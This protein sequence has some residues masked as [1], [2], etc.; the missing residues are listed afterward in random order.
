MGVNYN[1]NA[2]HHNHPHTPTAYTH[3]LT[4]TH[5]HAHTY[6]QWHSAV[7]SEPFLLSVFRA[8]SQHYLLVWGLE[9]MGKAATARKQKERMTYS[10]AGLFLLFFFG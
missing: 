9:T 10:I 1:M 7:H 8:P 4:H 3:R 6:T 5:T 2:L